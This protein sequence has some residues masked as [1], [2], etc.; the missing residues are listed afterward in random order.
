MG[1]RTSAVPAILI[2]A[3][4][5]C[6][7]PPPPRDIVLA[8]TTSVG[9]S[10]LLDAL[11][12][13]S[14]PD[15]GLRIR[16]HLVGSGLALRMLEKGDV[17]VVISHAPDAE[18]S[19]LK[20][21]PAWRYRKI[22]FNDFVVAG[23][24]ADPAGVRGAAAADVAMRR[25]ASSTA[26]FLSRGDGSGTHEREDQLWRL[27]GQRPSPDRLVVA[28]AGMGTTLRI[29][30]ETGAYTLSDRATLAQHAGTLRLAVLFEGGPLL[31]NTYAAIIDPSSPREADARAFFD[32]VT[33]GRGRPVI[34]SYRIG[35]TR[36]F[37]LW[38]TGVARDDP[39]ATPFPR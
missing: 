10:G 23:P 13:A 20:V 22:M 25:I 29:A 33:D 9:N 15:I 4:A 34:E 11:A 17:D 37:Q 21:H 39:Y 32:W 38:P 16:A 18:A 5:G 31:L 19:M 14:P 3:I 12:A 28:G 2:L 7:A 26:R 36:A 1:G 27:A 30:S 24:S 8:T 6:G 35:N